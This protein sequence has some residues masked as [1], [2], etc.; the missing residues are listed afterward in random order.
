MT[1]VSGYAEREAAIVMIE[2]HRPGRR[3][4]TLGA[5]KSER[6]SPTER[7]SCRGATSAHSA[8]RAMR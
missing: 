2:S 5:G 3:R 1:A 8:T 4:L 6:L 7:S